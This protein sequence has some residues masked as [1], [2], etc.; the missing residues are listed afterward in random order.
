MRRRLLVALRSVLIGWAI[1]LFI[2]FVLKH[3]LLAWI[4]P[5]LGAKWLATAGLALDCLALAAAGWVV[6]RLNRTSPIFGVLIFAATLTF[7]DFTP[8]LAIN[9]PWLL[10]L[11]ADALRDSGYLSSL[12]STLATQ[13]LLF[14][15]LLAGGLLSRPPEKPVSIA[16][17]ISR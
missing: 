12:V 9:I 1:L 17:D 11:A 3:P 8:V 5:I 4:A 2:A 16:A 7:W 15:S 6:G 10:R 14:G 13:A